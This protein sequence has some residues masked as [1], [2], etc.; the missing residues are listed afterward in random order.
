ME[1]LKMTLTKSVIS[2]MLAGAILGPVLPVYG[3]PPQ[4]SAP[5]SAAAPAPS[6]PHNWTMEQA[7]TSSVREAWAM[8]GKTPEGFFE[9]VKALAELSAQKRGVAVPEN[10]QSGVKAGAWINK[11]ARKDPDQLLY[12]IVDQAVQRSA[13]RTAAKAAAA[14]Q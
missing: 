3:A 14:G 8:G 11:Q 1:G 2:L 5:A 4:A 9:I 7:A 6:P 13:N 10:E 12:V